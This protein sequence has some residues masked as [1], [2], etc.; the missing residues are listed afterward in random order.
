MAKRPIFLAKDIPPFFEEKIIEFEFHNGF[1]KVQKQKSINSLHKAAKNTDLN[2]NILE[3]SNASLN[4]LGKN[5]SAFNLTIIYEGKGPFSV[6]SAFQSSKV[7]EFGG[8]YL[9][10]LV[11][12]SYISKKDERLKKSGK[13]ISFKFFGKDI[14]SEPKTLFYDW[15]YINALNQHTELHKELLNYNSF[16]DIEF[17]PNKSLNCQA[18][19]VAIF[20][21]LKKQG[22]INEALRSVEEFKKIVRYN[23]EETEI[24]SQGSLFDI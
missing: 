5:L 23:E 9:D 1:S 19:S 6:E 18:R 13:I 20:V 22:L 24:I 16:T 8:P 2:L 11:E 12:P 14:S 7:F 10:L 3:V 15:L 21:S 17:N 4:S